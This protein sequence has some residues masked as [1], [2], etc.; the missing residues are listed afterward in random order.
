[1]TGAVRLRAREPDVDQLISRSGHRWRLRRSTFVRGREV[2]TYCTQLH[3]AGA[4]Q[5][6]LN[7]GDRAMQEAWRQPRPAGP[8]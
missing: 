8:P 7:L 2:L 6:S 4:V 3:T 1:M 5:S